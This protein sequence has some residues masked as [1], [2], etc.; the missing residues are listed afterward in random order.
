MLDAEDVRV[1]S[2][3]SVAE[4]SISLGI[5]P[6]DR[7]EPPSIDV[8]VNNYNYARFLAAAIESALTQTF[9]CRAVIVVDDGSADES[10]AIIDSF[11]DQIV[12]VFKENGG[13]ASAFNA[14][15]AVSEADVVVFLDADDMLMPDAARR[16]VAAFQAAPDL[17][18]LHYRLAMIDESGTPTG[19][20]KPSP[21]IHLPVGDLRAATLRFP[22]DLA[23]P[24]TSGNAYAAR[25]LR[26][27]API[28]DCGD[29]NHADSYTVHLAALLGPVGAIDDPLAFYRLHGANSYESDQRSLD[30]AQVRVA[31]SISRRTRAFIDEFATGI[32]LTPSRNDYSMSEIGDR[33]ISLKLD[34]PGH[35]VPGD[36]LPVLIRLGTRAA[37]RR[38]DIAVP[39]KAAFVAWLLCLSC[40]PVSG[41]RWLAELYTFPAKRS[42][43]NGWLRKMSRR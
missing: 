6:T 10:R 25:V 13:Q 27:I 16:I 4:T 12:P 36:T 38:F 26:E 42:A 39:L 31:M 24:A 22:F 40:A 17:A 3:P 5:E 33:A 18:K 28:R 7:G 2:G 19:E 23:R 14:G 43:L 29:G 34:P 41:A 15:L 11:G 9:P 21:H 37:V 32:G 35:P 20:I 8:I 30:V 1:A